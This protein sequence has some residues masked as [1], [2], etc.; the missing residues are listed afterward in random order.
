MNKTYTK[1][2]KDIISVKKEDEPLIFI[3]EKALNLKRDNEELQ[4]RIDIAIEELKYYR[5]KN[6]DDLLQEE[7]FDNIIFI[8]QGSD[9]E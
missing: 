2:T 8:L 9:K 1:L 7:V 6:L 5:N 4:Q 3:S